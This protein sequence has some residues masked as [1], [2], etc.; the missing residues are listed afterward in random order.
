MRTMLRLGQLSLTCNGKVWYR[1]L[2]LAVLGAR[3]IFR[4]PQHQSSTPCCKL[5]PLLTFVGLTVSNV[6]SVVI[7]T[8]WKLADE[9]AGRRYRFS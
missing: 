6:V 2:H 1:V 8:F 3:N 5:C 7:E 4:S 9:E